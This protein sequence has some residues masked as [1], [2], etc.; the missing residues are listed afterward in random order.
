MSKQS[1]DGSAASFTSGRGAAA[2]GARGALTQRIE[3]LP[4]DLLQSERKLVDE[5]RRL[6]SALRLEFGWHYLLDLAWII[7]QL[8]DVR[9]KRIMDAGAGTGMMQ[10]YLAE[11][12]ADVISV[13]R[14]SRENLPLRFRA[15]YYVQ[16]LRP[17]D[18][19]GSSQVLHANLKRNPAAQARELLHTVRLG[20]SGGRAAGRVWIYNQDLSNLQ[21]L[22]DNSLDAIVAVSALEHNTQEGLQA[23]VAE[24]MRVL[25]PG[26]PLLATLTANKI[27]EW[28]VP[29]SGW[30]YSGSSLRRLFDLP[31]DAP[32]NYAEYDQ[33]FEQ[34]VG[35]SD[36]REN[37]A[38][39]YFR[40]GNNGMPWGKWDP[41]Y[42]P[43]GV[44]KIK[45]EN[46]K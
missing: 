39:F 3:L 6:A 7:R 10:W 11:H 12:G 34:L 37:L 38:K 16:G 21:Q 23:V 20:V 5:L 18:L 15:R 46:T 29:S 44:C 25:K 28:H 45:G 2:S 33:H 1:A 4:V 13:D 30:L 35:C 43:V 31:V 14:S 19:Q 36:L 26:A 32:D 42:M 24:L 17:E 9:G 41:Q 8:G 22:S 27:D 40:S